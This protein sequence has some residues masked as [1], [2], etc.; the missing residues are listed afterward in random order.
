MGNAD[1][2]LGALAHK[3]A[4]DIAFSDVMMPG[5]MN[6]VKLAQ[7]IHRRRP[8]LPALLTGTYTRAARQPLSAL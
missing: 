4:V 5:G 2:A 3:R 7:E 8:N 6:G 1:A